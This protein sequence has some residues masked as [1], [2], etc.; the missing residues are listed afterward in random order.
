MGSVVK[1]GIK[2]QWVAFKPGMQKQFIEKILKKSQ[3]TINDLAS[4]VRVSSRSFRDWKSEQARMN[5]QALE[6]L[7]K[8]F[9]ISPGEDRVILVE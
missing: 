7:S 3:L 5:L 2:N 9:R 8:Q 6:I 4:M 1:Q